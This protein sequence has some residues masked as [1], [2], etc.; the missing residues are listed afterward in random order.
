[1]KDVLKATSK[2]QLLVIEIKCGNEIFPE[3]QKVIKEYWK[4]GSIAFIGFNFETISLAKANFQEV[5]CYYLSSSK[6]DVLKRIP[7][8]K[9]NKLDGVDLN[10]KIIDQQLVD[11]LQKANAE[12]W[13]W[14]VDAVDE[15]MRMKNLGVKTITTNRPTF[16][17]EQMITIK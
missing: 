10:S 17:K 5:P 9:K 12:I 4:T 1:L 15:A 13:C 16:L 6:E 11:M 14:T 8:I 7:D 3:L 2:G